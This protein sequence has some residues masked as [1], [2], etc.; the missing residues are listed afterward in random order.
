MSELAIVLMAVMV[1]WLVKQIVDQV[2][3]LRAAHL[4]FGQLDKLTERL[5]ASLMQMNT[6]P[7]TST[8]G[9]GFDAVH[10]QASMLHEVVR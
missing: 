9:N 7:R 5:V 2:I 8:N 4:L 1:V 10:T 3:G 6:Q